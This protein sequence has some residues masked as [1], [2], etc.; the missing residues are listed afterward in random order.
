MTPAA[1]RALAKL[2]RLRAGPQQDAAKLVLVDGLRQ[3]DAARK[4]GASTAAV[5]NTVAACRAG[6]SLAK[7]AIGSEIRSGD[8]SD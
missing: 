4:T 6:I 1:F 5:G 3:V 8:A 2:L 7:A